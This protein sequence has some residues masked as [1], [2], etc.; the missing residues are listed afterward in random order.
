[1]NFRAYWFLWLVTVCCAILSLLVGFMAEFLLATG[2]FSSRA[3][4]RLLE[5]AELAKRNMT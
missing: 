1:M 4:D 2:H 5:I 3:A